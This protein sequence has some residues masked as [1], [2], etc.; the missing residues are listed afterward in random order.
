M[1]FKLRRD[2][3]VS[4]DKESSLATTWM[5]I[6]ALTAVFGVVVYSIAEY[7]ANQVKI[8]TVVAANEPNSI[9]NRIKPIGQVRL[10]G[11]PA[12]AAKD[13]ANNNTAAVATPAAEQSPGE[14]VY[15]SA[16]LA[17]HSTGAAGAPKLGDTAAWTPRSA[18]GMAVLLNHAL[19]GFN[20]MPARG[21]NAAL[22][23][24]DIKAAIGFMLAQAKLTAETPAPA[25]ETPATP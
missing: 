15:S 6:I 19:N 17:C 11:E 22:T 4:T 8:V 14:R 25:A 23:D 1:K 16:C 12:P 13:N 7:V 20:A 9:E 18:Q 5:T 10:A 2:E 24:D 3:P 21:G